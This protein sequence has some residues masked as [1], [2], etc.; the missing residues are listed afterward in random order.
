LKLHNT[1]LIVLFPLPVCLLQRYVQVSLP[2]Y[3]GEKYIARSLG[4]YE[5]SKALIGSAYLIKPDIIFP[6]LVTTLIGTNLPFPQ[7]GQSGR[8]SSN[9]FSSMLGMVLNN[10]LIFAT[11]A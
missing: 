10:S 9:E 6:H 7:K 5:V 2:L 8:K 1:L 11:M 3:I 4:F